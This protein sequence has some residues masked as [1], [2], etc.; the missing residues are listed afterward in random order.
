[1]FLNADVNWL[2]VVV[3]ALVGFAVSFVWWGPLFGKQW[4]K[5]VGFSQAQAKKMHKQGMGK[6]IVIAIIAQIIMAWVLAMII[7]SMGLV[8]I[9]QAVL[10][11]FHIWIGFVA[12]VGVGIVLWEGKP[13]GLFWLNTLGWLVTIVV[14]AVVL[15]MWN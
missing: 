8:G 3:S 9:G 2:A 6:K 15:G 13:W 5:L 10:L 1:M 14:M 12:T 4:L 7:S 11:A